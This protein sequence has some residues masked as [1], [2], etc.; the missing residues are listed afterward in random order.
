MIRHPGEEVDIYQ[1][2]VT[3]TEEDQEEE[4]DPTMEAMEE[5]A[6]GMIQIM[7]TTTLNGVNLSI[8]NQ[9]TL[10]R[11]IM[12]KK[13]ELEEKMKEMNTK[14]DMKT[15]TGRGQKVEVDLQAELRTAECNTKVEEDL[16]VETDPPVLEDT[17]NMK[18]TEKAAGEG[19]QRPAEIMKLKKEEKMM[20]RK[21]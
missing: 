17:E 19:L 7:K 16:A 14:E 11:E 21:E 8:Q 5:E 20:I 3:S 13:E 1:E 15:E 18:R 12:K 10:K 4:E 6:D 9:D 2:A